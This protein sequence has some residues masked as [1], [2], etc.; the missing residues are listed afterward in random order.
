MLDLDH[1]GVLLGSRNMTSTAKVKRRQKVSTVVLFDQ[2]PIIIS[3]DNHLSLF[4]LAQPLIQFPSPHQS[5]SIP[6]AA[7]PAEGSQCLWTH[8][9][10]NS[11]VTILL[12]NSP[13]PTHHLTNDRLPQQLQL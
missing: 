10:S 12:L 5:C 1:A 9:P 4:L 11:T 8:T 3:Q 2:T 7:V 6:A 13:A